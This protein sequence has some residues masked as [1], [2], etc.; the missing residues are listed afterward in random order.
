MAKPIWLLV[1]L[2]AVLYLPIA[3]SGGEANGT[4]T[5]LPPV[6]SSHGGNVGSGGMTS[7]GSGG[8]SSGSG[9]GDDGTC[10]AADCPSGGFCKD[11]M[12]ACGANRPE[13]CTGA[14]VG[15][16]A[17]GICTNRMTD[18]NNC[19]ECGMKCD[20]GAVCMEGA[21]GAAPTDIVTAT[22]CGTMR[23]AIQGMNV[24][25]T[26]TMTGKVMT[27]P[28]A[29]GAAVEVATG[30]LE[31]TQIAADAMGVYWVNQGDATAGSS[32]VMKKAL[33]LAAGAPVVL[34]A[35]PDMVKI[36]AITVAAGKLYYGLGHDVHAIST[37]EAVTT[38]D[39]VGTATDFDNFPPDGMPSGEPAG[40]AVSGT[41]LFWTTATRQG[42]ESDDTAPGTEGY[43][44]L[45]DSQGSLLKEYIASDGTNGYWV[46]GANF[47]RA[48]KKPLVDIASTPDFDNITAF[49]MNAT[50]V[51]FAGETGLVLKHDLMPPAMG[52]TPSAATPVV[53][54][55]LKTTSM[56]LDA[57]KVYWA[58][59]CVVRSSAL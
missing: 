21:C 9:G 5:P 55:Q 4:K 12:C 56:V 34:K 1:P 31:P 28:L 46:D 29:G 40:L 35:S 7:G 25:W 15:G 3:C 19:G 33:P 43:V 51:Y 41:R 50:N 47:R 42:V 36:L 45:G 2:S 48:A 39:I 20:A 6:G 22:G 11:G 57:A 38:D 37:D 16:G 58:S 52:A 32:K 24:Y 8:A 30:Q 27:A 10:K 18:P 14:N 54:E 49:A 44:E 17:N 23:L 53:R 13:V 59:D 26:E